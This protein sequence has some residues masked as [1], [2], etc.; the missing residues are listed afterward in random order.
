M[1]TL[2][3]ELKRRF[4]ATGDSSVGAQLIRAVLK[5]AGIVGGVL[6]ESSPTAEIVYAGWNPAEETVRI[7]TMVKEYELR[8]HRP[9]LKMT[10]HMEKWEEYSYEEAWSDYFN[11]SRGYIALTEYL[12]SYS[13][14][15]D[16]WAYEGLTGLPHFD[17]KT[18][19]MSDIRDAVM[20]EQ[21]NEIPVISQ[22]D[23][24]I[25]FAD[26]LEELEDMPEL[27]ESG[28]EDYPSCG[29]D[30]CPSYWSTGEQA[31]QVCVCGASLPANS[32]Y[33]I[34]DSCLNA[35]D[36]DDPYGRHGY[37]GDYEAYDEDVC[38]ECGQFECECD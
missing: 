2:T 35:P 12:Y 11:Q 3:Q 22:L 29:H 21:T 26:E 30:I 6:R 9:E 4:L 14:S 15:T 25:T 38:P 37:D 23:S 18:S 20:E 13:L 34:C 32:R 27:L 17:P 24:N 7:I 31:E 5:T 16:V 1:D 8:I 36:P 10:E 33:S 28:C 19:T